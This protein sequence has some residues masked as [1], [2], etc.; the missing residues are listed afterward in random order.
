MTSLIADWV[1]ALGVWSW[2][3]LG[4]L[5]LL[6][7]VLIPGVYLFWFGLAALAVAVQSALIPLPWQVQIGFFIVYSGV[8]I[9]LARRIQSRDGDK[10]DQPFLNKRSEALVGRSATLDGAIVDGY[11]NVRIDDTHW[12]VTGPDLAAGTRVVIVGTDGTTLKVAHPDDA[13]A[14]AKDGDKI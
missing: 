6:V 14:Q 4:G 9:W 13:A 3:V 12:R 10:S 1:A 7:E 2:A 11:G 5:L 8:F